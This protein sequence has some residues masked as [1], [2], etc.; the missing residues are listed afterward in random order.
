MLFH[1]MAQFFTAIIPRIS[2]QPQNIPELTPEAIDHWCST[3][4]RTDP[5]KLL[6]TFNTILKQSNQQNL[7]PQNRLYLL[8]KMHTPVISTI[9]ILK[10]TLLTAY[11][12]L[13]REQQYQHQQF[14]SIY[15]QLIIGYCIILRQKLDK[16][17]KTWSFLLAIDNKIAI[18]IQRLFRYYGQIILTEFELYREPEQYLWQ[19]LYTLFHFSEQK[20]FSNIQVYDPLLK[21]K[22]TI[23]N[24][25]L[26]I[27]LLALS[28]P[29][30]Y[31]QQQIYFI[32]KQLAIWAKWVDICS[33]HSPNSHFYTA[34]NLTDHL[35]PTFYPRGIRPELKEALYIDTHNLTLEHLAKDNNAENTFLT[36]KSKQELLKTLQKA[37]TTYVERRFD[38]NDY[39]TQMKVVH[40]LGNVHFVLNHYQI[41]EYFQSAE[42]TSKLGQIEN[43]IVEEE[44]HF[45][46]LGNAAI[47][48]GETITYTHHN[49]PDYQKII[50]T[51]LT[52]NESLNGLSLLWDKTQPIEVKIG[53]LICLSHQQKEQPDE[54]FVGVIR[55]IQHFTHQALRIGVQILS[56]EPAY[57]VIICKTFSQRYYRALVLPA[58]GLNKSP[59]RLLLDALTFRENETIFLLGNGEDKKTLT[60]GK[61][62]DTTNFFECFTFQYK[63]KPQ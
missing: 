34:I 56:P 57:P 44:H 62:V 30:H 59:P 54:W 19:E 13:T 33:H 16:K 3:L 40:G 2:N 10:K 5:Q 60:L 15:R 47:Q 63:E 27:I 7:K 9:G 4:N 26:Q 52:E 53:E 36:E 51:L 46:E 61:E 23:K 12:P 25:L 45:D 31:N 43:L 8:E 35:L 58:F 1:D 22:T 14:I 11:L 39:Y 24:T 41:E 49:Q 48:D 29:Y 37:W 17:N 38:R 20:G 50:H 18:C 28:D 6:T 32:Y 42:Y 21:D 55:R